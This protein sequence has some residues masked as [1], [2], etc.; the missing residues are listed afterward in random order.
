VDAVFQ[1]VVFTLHEQRYALRLAAVDRIVRV[2][3]ITALPSAPTIVLG[4]VNVQGRVIP[5]VDTSRRF[6]LPP[7]DVELSDQLI[8]ARTSR[9]TVALLVAAVLGVIDCSQSQIDAGGAIL[10]DT[11]YV[12][13]VL[14]LDDGLLLIH[15]LDTFLSSIE[16]RQLTH[17]LASA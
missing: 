16:D 17:A 4:V 8:I 10:A 1:F 11:R 2:V 5:V 9:R 15:D 12:E 6:G 3:E 7:Q 14:K 13:G